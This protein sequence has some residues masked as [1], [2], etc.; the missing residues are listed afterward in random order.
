MVEINDSLLLEFLEGKADD[1]ATAE[2]E[3]W[4]DASEANRRHLERLYFVLFTGDRL[5]AAQHANP[6]RGWQALR[7]RIEAEERK[8]RMNRI[9]ATMRYA[10]IFLVGV[11]LS[12]AL[13]Y[14]PERSDNRTCLVETEDRCC[15]I[16]LSDSSTVRLMPHSRLR[17]AADFGAERRVSLAGAA[18]FDI[19][20]NAASPFTVATRQG[21][22]V[23][24]RGTKF[25]MK[26]Y[27]DCSDIETLL[28]EGKV[29]FHAG[30]RTVTLEP[31][32]KV[33]YNPAQKS[34]AVR[35]VN[36]EEE[37]N[38]NQR[39]FQYVRLAQIAHSLNA[40]YHCT[41]DFR[42][43]G[44]GMIPFTGTLDFDMPLRHILEILTISTDTRFS[45]SGDRILIYR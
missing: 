5:A 25:N 21:A 33:S 17:Y 10:A 32:Q 27:R 42:D 44:L 2:I 19:R 12:A 4:Y 40:Y 7:R 41:I 43:D 14:R 15:T 37:L 23:V 39:S 3:R 28:V 16:H 6:E 31:G 24:V 35:T 36:I 11:L 34:I 18:F 13:L 9:S 45:R 30:N 26:A 8:R 38:S 20:K 1:A 22:E 29:D